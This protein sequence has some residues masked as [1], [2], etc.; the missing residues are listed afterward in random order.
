VGLLRGSGDRVGDRLRGRRGFDPVARGVPGSR[1]RGELHGG[2]DTVRAVAD[3]GVL[4]AGGVASDARHAQ[5]RA[6]AEPRARIPVEVEPEAVAVEVG[7][8]LD[9]LLP[10]EVA[11]EQVP[12]ALLP[13]RETDGLVSL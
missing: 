4:H 3:R 12:Q 11:A 9:A 10:R 5:V 13:A 1:E 2:L 7:A 8:E 6:P